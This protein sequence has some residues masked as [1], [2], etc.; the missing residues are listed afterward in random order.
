[1]TDQEIID[2]VTAHKNGKSIQMS[3]LNGEWV[4]CDFPMWNFV[5]CRYRVKP[6]PR[7][8]TVC[9]SDKGEIASYSALMGSTR[10][11]NIDE[12]KVREVLE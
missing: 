5:G 6:E 9:I 4:D 3:I 10:S 7:E 8:W 12:V 11:W 1:M 2:V